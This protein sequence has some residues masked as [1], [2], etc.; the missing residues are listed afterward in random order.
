[1][2]TREVPG[3]FLKLVLEIAGGERGVIGESAGC[4]V[5]RG[6]AI[7]PRSSRFAITR[8]VLQSVLREGNYVLCNNAIGDGRFSSSRSVIRD[9]IGSL[10]AAPLWMEGRLIG[11]LYVDSLDQVDVFKPAHL[12]VLAYAGL[13]MAQVLAEQQMAQELAQ[14][15]AAPKPLDAKAEQQLLQQAVAQSGFFRANKRETRI[16]AIAELGRR[17]STAGLAEILPG[18][19]DKDPIIAAACASALEAFGAHSFP[20]ESA[21]QFCDRMLTEA[22]AED[23]A[24]RQAITGVLQRVGEQNSLVRMELSQRAATGGVLPDS[25]R[26]VLTRLKEHFE[27]KMAISPGESEASL[28]VSSRPKIPLL[29]FD[30]QKRYEQARQDWIKSGRLGPEP[31]PPSS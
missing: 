15:E 22:A 17:R 31:M 25:V 12:W 30:R 24:R 8:I 10:I 27:K 18:L 26:A 9:K 20:K 21:V 16:Q 4:N 11:Y 5:L 7:L 28:Q 2:A 14:S 23:V 29:D 13:Q 3:E 6:G 19:T 1:L